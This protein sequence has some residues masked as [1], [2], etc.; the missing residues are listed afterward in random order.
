M[1]PGAAQPITLTVNGSPHP[2]VVEPRRVLV[3]VLRHD[4]GLTGTKKVCGM[5]DCG[6][7]TVIVDGH[8]MYSCLLLAVD[9]EGRAITT[10]EGLAH[11]QRL[12]PVQEAFIRC[13]AFQCGFCTAGQI[14]SLRALLDVVPDPT[15]DQIVRAVTGNLCRC[16]AYRNILAAGRLAADLQRQQP[17]RQD[18]ADAQ[19]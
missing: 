4:L 12:D 10:I 1:A 8:A 2:L 13:D 17:A 3:D 11:G 5:G 15:D 9:C 18:S 6:A 16:G 7:C 14:M 19:R